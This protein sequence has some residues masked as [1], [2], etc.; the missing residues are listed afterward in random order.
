M[1]RAEALLLANHIRD[2]QR[3]LEEMVLSHQPWEISEI[4]KADGAG[5]LTPVPVVHKLVPLESLALTLERIAGL[6]P[7]PA[8]SGE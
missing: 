1:T 8:E 4:P 7:L 5:L 6:P 3:E 2:I